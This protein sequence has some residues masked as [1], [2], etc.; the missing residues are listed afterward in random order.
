VFQHPDVH[1]LLSVERAERLRADAIDLPRRRGALR[2][3]PTFLQSR[4]TDRNAPAW[5]GT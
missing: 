1:R 2:K 3:M 5:K 4:V